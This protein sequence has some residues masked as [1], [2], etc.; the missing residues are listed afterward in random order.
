[1][2]KMIFAATILIAS[3]AS[4]GEIVWRSP[5]SGTLTA[6]SDPATPPT[7]PEQPAFGIRYEPISVAAGTSVVIKPVGD[8]SGYA[9][10]LGQ[11]LPPGLIFDSPTGRIVGVAAVAGNHSITVRAAKDDFYADLVLLLTVS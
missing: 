10:S 7:E 8:V 4:A 11:T 6:V 3:S 1:M 2:L 5:T 9:F